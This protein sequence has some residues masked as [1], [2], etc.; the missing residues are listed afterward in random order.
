MCMIFTS[1]TPDNED[2]EDNEETNNE[3][4]D[5]T[6][7]DYEDNKKPDDEP[8]TSNQHQPPMQPYG[9]N[10]NLPIPYIATLELFDTFQV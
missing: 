5:T 9:M 3:S 6:E 10:V 4:T 8:I 7:A 2:I 1:N